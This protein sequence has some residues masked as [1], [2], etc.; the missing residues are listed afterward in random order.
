MATIDNPRSYIL[1]V[2]VGE[3]IGESYADPSV[4]TAAFWPLT[5][6]SRGHVH[7]NSSDPFDDPIITP[8]FLSDTFDQDIAVALSK[9][10]RTLF[11]TAPISGVVSN[12]FYSPDTVGPN[13]T[14]AEWLAWYE[15]SSFGASHWL[16][17]TAMMPEELGGVVNSNLQ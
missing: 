17:S 9:S 13:A 6:L 16:G 12:A 14:D 15:S 4:L 8:R 3:F 10:S 5:P 7:I 11:Q 2:P 1:A